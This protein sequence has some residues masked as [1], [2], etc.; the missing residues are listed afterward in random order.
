MKS[1]PMQNPGSKPVTPLPETLHE[2]N[3][4]RLM[5]LGQWEYASRVTSK[6]V[7]V[8]VA[9]TPSHEL[10]LVE[11]FRAPVGRSVIELPAG[12]AG[13][14]PEFSGESLET[15][16]IRELEEETGWRASGMSLLAN[17]PV[18]AGMSSEIVSFFRAQGLIKVGQGGGD[19]TEAI[20][21]HAVP[22][23]AV[24]DFLRAKTAKGVYVDPKIYTGLYF[25]NP[26]HW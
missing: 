4:L 16:A 9:V 2:G 20:T 14:L 19:P 10:I 3:F 6:G 13:D 23:G 8:I 7:V 25:A 1:K 26:Q 24:E 5:R 15:A 21:V 22:L 12:V 17:G 11:Q 18:S